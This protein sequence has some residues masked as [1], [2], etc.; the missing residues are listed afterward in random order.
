[1]QICALTFKDAA[2]NLSHDVWFTSIYRSLCLGN[3]MWDYK[4]DCNVVSEQFFEHARAASV[5]LKIESF[6][7]R[8]AI[9]CHAVTWRA[10][11]YK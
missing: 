7:A 11:L 4:A 1:M 8:M 6:P 2:L 3:R 9:F 10:C 5:M